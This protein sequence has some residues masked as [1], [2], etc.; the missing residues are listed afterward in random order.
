VDIAYEWVEAMRTRSADHRAAA[1]PGT[2]R[3]AR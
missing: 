1:G 2:R 3:S